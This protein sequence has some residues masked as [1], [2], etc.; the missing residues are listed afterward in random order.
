MGAAAV[1]RCVRED[2]P[3]DVAD[4]ATATGLHPNTV[5]KHLARLERAGLVVSEIDRSGRP[6]RPLRRYRTVPRQRS[7]ISLVVSAVAGAASAHG[8]DVRAAGDAVLVEHCPLAD[9]G[10]EVG[11]CALHQGLARGAAIA[12]GAA[13]HLTRDR[14]T[15]ACCFQFTSTEETT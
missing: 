14:I 6:G 10:T 4:L 9:A 7:G 13:L 5:R 15:G 3:Q 8:L 12:V 11:L 1:L 2:A